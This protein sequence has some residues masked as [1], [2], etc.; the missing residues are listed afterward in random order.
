MALGRDGLRAPGRAGPDRVGPIDLLNFGRCR[1]LK[2]TSALPKGNNA[3]CKY[4]CV[5]A[6]VCSAYIC[7]ESFTGME[8]AG[9]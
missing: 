2:L 5:R 7:V 1:T 6:C 4:V 8:A 9:A 3:L